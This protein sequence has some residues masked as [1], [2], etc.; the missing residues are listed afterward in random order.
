MYHAAEKGG[1]LQRPGYM[2]FF[3]ACGAGWPAAEALWAPS[4]VTSGAV[5]DRGRG[6][7]LRRERVGGDTGGDAAAAIFVFF[8]NVVGGAA[9]WRDEW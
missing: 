8:V 9:G 5:S 2:E 4:R 6:T 1:H 7:F 3:E